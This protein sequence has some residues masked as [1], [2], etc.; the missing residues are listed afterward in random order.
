V[1]TTSGKFEV[2]LDHQELDSRG[3]TG[4][5]HWEGLGDLLNAQERRVGRGYLEMTRYAAPL[6]L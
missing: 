6:C 1:Q 2:L 4:E 5:L 3:S